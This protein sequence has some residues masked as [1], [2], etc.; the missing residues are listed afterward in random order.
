M[1]SRYIRLIISYTKCRV[2]VIKNN[3]AYKYKLGRN[4]GNGFKTVY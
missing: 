1:S 3:T 2:Q 4:S